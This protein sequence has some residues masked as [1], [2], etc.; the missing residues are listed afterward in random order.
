MAIWVLLFIGTA[1]LSDAA[2]KPLQLQDINGIM[3]R[4]FEQHVSQK[5]ISASILKHSFKIYVDQFDPTRSYLLES[6]IKPFLDLSDNEATQILNEYNKGSYSTYTA[7][8]N[9][10]QKAIQRN[11]QVRVKLEKDPDSLYKKSLLSKS[12]GHEEWSDPDLK[13]AFAQNDKE[14]ELR[15]EKSILKFIA[16]ERTR[17][18]KAYVDAHHIQI[19][20]LFERQAL[21]RENPYLFLSNSNQSMSNTEKENQQAIFILKAL[22]NVLDAHTTVLSTQEADEMR[23]RL[24]KEIQGIGIELK[25]VEGNFIV[26]R[27]IQGGPAQIS[28]KISVNDKVIELDGI[29]V[30]N[31]SMHEV[32]SM[33]RGTAGTKISLKVQSAGK[34]SSGPMT[35]DL[36]RK[37]IPVNEDRVKTEVQ[38]FGNGIIGILKLN[39]FYQSDDGI[40]SEND[41]REAIA[42]MKEKGNLRGLILDFRENSGGFLSQAV[43]VGGLF[44]SSGIIVIS[45][46]FNGEEHF[47]RDIDGKE[48]YDRPLIILTSKATASAAEIVAQALQDYGVAV[49]VGDEH[50]YGKGTIQSQTVTGNQESAYFKVTVGTY[51][52]VSGK[53]PQIQGVK[54]DIV[55]PS[56]FAHEKMGEE[57]LE[58]ALKP[59]RI[60]PSF[61]DDL[62]DI[63]SNLRSWYAHYYT[64]RLQ[65]EKTI[66]H[67]LMPTLK[68]NSFYRMQNNSRY[69]QFLNGQKL[70]FGK[71]DLQMEEAVNILKDMIVLYTQQRAPEKLQ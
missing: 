40:T 38:T 65:H 44:I 33:L 62:H 71:N 10:I 23:L 41:M 49:I 7:L 36:V 48:V 31:K 27:I 51:Y 24:E 3:N 66:W 64:P 26:S 32:L 70:T 13:Q 22:A 14:L 34:S 19:L 59:D 42:K 2:Q 35:V 46:Y 39:S 45:K 47:Y 1:F 58:S 18:G 57:F 52:T 37:D 53:T 68:T 11:R 25:L 61:E 60:S 29:A 56:P 63:S 15:T 12:D 69:Q 20:N 16:S 54:A 50:T 43:K 4:I 9:V 17:F 21:A 67:E 6:D 8:N 55:V 28:G 5:E 30:H